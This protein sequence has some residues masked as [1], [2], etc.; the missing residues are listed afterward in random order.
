MHYFRHVATDKNKCNS[1]MLLKRKA[2]EN[3]RKIN[4]S[5]FLR[6]DSQVFK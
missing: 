4:R 6:L 1:K 5:Q 3:R 2:K